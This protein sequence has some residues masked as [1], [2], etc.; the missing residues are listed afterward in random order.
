MKPAILFFGADWCPHCRDFKEV[1]AKLEEKFGD[2]IN[3]YHVDLVKYK[4]WGNKF[5][6]KG[7][8]DIRFY[9]E[10]NLVKYKGGKDVIALSNEI[11]EHFKL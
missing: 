8:P 10:G 5:K 2:K 11:K 6:V 3:F 9:K 4:K 7:I 1:W